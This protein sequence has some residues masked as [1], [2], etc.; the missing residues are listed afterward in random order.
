MVYLVFV[1]AAEPGGNVFGSVRMVFHSEYF[2]SYRESDLLFR[3]IFW[4]SWPSV[5]QIHQYATSLSALTITFLLAKFT[6]LI[7]EKRWYYHR[8]MGIASGKQ[9]K[10]SQIGWKSYL[11]ECH[12]SVRQMF[13]IAFELRWIGHWNSANCTELN[14]IYAQLSWN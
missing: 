5:E 9:Y 3:I 10:T 14:W 7:I 12:L 1:I 4:I 8:R 6:Y 11:H 13:W 2:V